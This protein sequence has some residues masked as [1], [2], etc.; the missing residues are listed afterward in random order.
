VTV[1]HGHEVKGGGQ[2]CPPHT[3]LGAAGATILRDTIRHMLRMMVVTAHPDDEAS[4][5]GGSLRL[6]RE[7]GVET[8]VICLT[9]GQAATYRGGAHHD[10]ELVLMRRKEFADA[11]AILKVSRGLVLDYPDGQLH[12]LDMQRV[13]SDLALRIRE[14][15]PQVLL[16]FDSGG[17]VTG[18]TDHSMASIFAT[19]AF[20]WAGRNNRF[21]DQLN[22]SVSPHQPQK[23][24]YTTADFILPGRQ[25][26]TLAPITTTIEIGEYLETKIDAFR[27]HLSQQPLWLLFEEYARKRG[28]RELFHLVAAVQADSFAPES[29]LFAGVSE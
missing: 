26:V 17:S 20:H 19:L 22:S 15:R 21:P 8:C 18:H 24:Y 3:T 6:Y 11:C 9:P 7:R 23:L 4:S 13:V 2:E 5:F 1:R 10:H 14:F 16:T 25:P 29:D 27:A 28:R 12:R